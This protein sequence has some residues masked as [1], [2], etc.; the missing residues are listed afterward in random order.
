VRHRTR[1]E[2]YWRRLSFERPKATTIMY[3]LNS[4]LISLLGAELLA[5]CRTT[6]R[7]SS[8]S[9][10]GLF[11]LLT[12]A[13][14]LAASPAVRADTLVD[15]GATL[16]GRLPADQL[17]TISV[18]LPLRNTG[19]L[20]SLIKRLYD[21][22]DA[23]YGHYLKPDEFTDRFGPTLDDVQ[24]VTD[25]AKAH[26]LAVADVSANRTVVH[27]TGREADVE[28][29]FGVHLLGYRRADGS[30]FHAPDTSP[31]I[32][33][34]LAGRV[35][36]VFGLDTSFRPQRYSHFA[37]ASAGAASPDG[38]DSLSFTGIQG[39]DPND[40]RSVYDLPLNSQSTNGTGQT[41][42]VFEMDGWT[43]SD[44]TTWENQYS[45]S[46]V[47]P[48]LKSVDGGDGTPQTFGGASETEL[49]IEM[50]LTLCP[51]ASAILV[52][53][54]PG[55]D[56][57][58]QALDVMNQMATDDQASVIS[59]SY[60]GS[61]QDQGT[62]FIMAEFQ[63]FAQ[64]AAQGQ[65][66]CAAAGDAGAYND[67]TNY[68]NTPTVSDPA[69]DPYVLAVGGTFLT[70][71]TTETYVS[72]SSW[73]SPHTNGLPD[74]NGGGGGISIV[75]SIPSYQIG[76]FSTSVNTQGS[77]TM[78]NL[79]D[80]SAFGD[81]NEG[82]YSIYITDPTGQNAPQWYYANGTSASSPLWASFLGNVN[83][84]RQS[85]GFGNIGLA[86]PAIYALAENATKYA[87]DFHDIADGSNNLLYIAVAGY[88]NSTGWGSFNCA[89]LLADLGAID[90]APVVSSLLFNSGQVPDNQ[91]PAGQSIQAYV[92]LSGAAPSGGA[93]VAI[94]KGTTTVAT[95]VVPAGAT[96][97]PFSLSIAS[98]VAPG[99]YTYKA[100]YDG[101]S[102]SAILVVLPA[103][104]V[105]SV[106]LNPSTILVTGST[107]VTIALNEAAPSSGVEV[108]WLF[109]GSNE[110]QFEVGGGSNSVSFFLSFPQVG[111]YT[112]SGELGTSEKSATLTI[113]A[114]LPTVSSVSL[115]KSSIE[116]GKTTT[117]TVTLS[118]AAPTGGAVVTL[119]SSNTSAATVPATV[120]VAAGSSS[121][122]FTITAA[123]SVTSAL[124]TSIGASYNSS[125]QSA[126]LT[127]TPP[128]PTVTSLTLLKATIVQ[129]STTTGTVTISSAAPAAGEKVTL[130]S[131]DTAAATVP[132]SVTIASG[133]TSKTFTI[134]AATSISAS[135][136]TTITASLN[137]TSQDAILTVD[138]P[139]MSTLTLNPTTVTG[140]AGS[141]GT[142]TLTGKAS[143]AFTVDL[144]S[145]DPAI[146]SV[147]PSVT[148]VAGSK[149]ATFPVT[150][151]APGAATKVTIKAMADGAVLSAKVTVDP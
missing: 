143:P 9:A 93:S 118:A 73:D 43:P 4:K 44:I 90:P 108:T 12:I 120:T 144:T 50:E 101:G 49:D 142:I 139:A 126:T 149:T 82:G 33:G 79:P 105:K 141:T 113:V 8:A 117:G 140:T 76:S 87:S 46:S 107:L 21:P 130:T 70:D 134:T 66:Y 102:A 137:G 17:M 47:T 136:P 147:P 138:P 103:L 10:I 35:V 78:R 68:P 39:L 75:W 145:S 42:A 30:Q 67:Q 85:N 5:A 23:L 116:Q 65:T 133:A 45:A 60:G 150:T 53:Q 54:A 19:A 88:D 36:G 64:M 80:V 15:T 86:Q 74:G 72:E 62:S 95:V 122:T 37:P 25:F 32:P 124:T 98:N 92:T 38:T 132:K 55:N 1:T 110:G 96:G 148:V 129:G 135:T 34:T 52:Y 41:L 123:A 51:D 56:Y 27:L 104:A 16:I 2:V 28:A 20:Q 40:V 29:A 14:A 81:F 115:L 26:N 84:L 57:G 18:E 77:T 114:S 31:V 119:S 128:P 69:S 146:A 48:T 151:T 58:Q 71:S 121:K 7:R 59:M 63:A 97:A 89:N 106:T 13:T 11:A 24:T 111:Q 125:S 127:V 109:D 112:I 22:K 3:P 61:E 91:A 6:L 94:T 99:T 100:T 83:E 131:S